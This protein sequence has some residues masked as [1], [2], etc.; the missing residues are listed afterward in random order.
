MP[1]ISPESRRSAAL[2]LMSCSLI[3]SIIAAART[4]YMAFA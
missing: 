3:S 4:G 1:A 2:K